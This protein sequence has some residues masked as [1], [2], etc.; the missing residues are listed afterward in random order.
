M[1]AIPRH[2]DLKRML[3]AFERRLYTLEL[4]QRSA[5]ALTARV[6]ELET[7]MVVMQQATSVTRQ[8][9]DPETTESTNQEG[10]I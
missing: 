4:G 6:E 3:A 7:R 5:S 2:F 9:V 10:A 1:T 8:T